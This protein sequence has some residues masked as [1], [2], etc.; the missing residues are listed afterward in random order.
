MLT[1]DS[2]FVGD[3]ARPDLA[4]EPEE[5]ARD[6][7]RSLH[8][9][10]FTLPASV[11]V[12][13][14]HLG[15]S[16]CGSSGI[17]HRTSSTIGFE[18]AHNHVVGF[19]TADEFVADAVA[20]LG[21]PPAQ[22]RARR[23]P[24]PRAAGRGARGAGAAQPARR[25][26]RDRRRRAARR[27]AHQRPVR[28]GAHP[29]RDQRLGLRHR[30]RD[31]GRQGRPAGRRADRRRRLRRLR[32][33]RRRPA[34]LGR[35]A[36]RAASSVGG[37]TAWRSEGRQVEPARADR[38]RRS[39][40]SGSTRRR[41]ARSCSTSA[42]RVGVRRRPHSRLD[43]HP[44]RRARRPARRAPDRPPDRRRSAA[45]ASAAA[46]PPRSCSARASSSV[47]HVGN[48]GVGTWKRAGRQPIERPVAEPSASAAAR[49]GRRL[50]RASARTRCG[51]RARR[52]R[53]RRPCARASLD[54]ARPSIVSVAT[55]LS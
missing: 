26:G 35:P 51:A 48:G 2:L 39:S 43:P 10:L 21:R 42:T 31:Q 6:L 24:Q 28:R 46:S 32:A 17:D 8:E 16:L 44:L 38:P 25:R 41:R 15:G 9:R 23:R 22:R 47:I 14:G 49:C 20:S 18:L 53:G 52:S 19:A 36:G 54:A 33:R 34:R 55:W 40:P 29:R 30:L 45:A 7:Y 4:V 5:G 12:W 37:M 13:P 3:V 50:R 11:E 27:R 1:G